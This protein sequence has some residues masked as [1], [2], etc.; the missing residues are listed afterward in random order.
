MKINLS[1]VAIVLATIAI[2]ISLSQPTDQFLVNI[3][4]SDEGK[5]AFNVYDFYIFH[6]F[7]RLYIRNNGTA[8]AHNIGI[9]LIFTGFALSN[10]EATQFIP[11][12]REGFAVI[13]EFPIGQYQLES[14]IPEGQSFTNVSQYEAIVHIT[15]NELAVPRTFNFQDF[16]S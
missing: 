14:T 6:T 11:E 10:W 13:L 4:S 1:I 7:T 5:P 3:N 12:I 15:C 2:I 8:T 9:N 16:I